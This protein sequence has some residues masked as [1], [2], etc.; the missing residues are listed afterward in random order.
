[1]YVVLEATDKSF[2]VSGE[3]LTLDEAGNHAETLPCQ[4]HTDHRIV[5]GTAEHWRN[6]LK[7]A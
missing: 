5:R 2:K 6:V 4:P 3:F 1:M 7:A